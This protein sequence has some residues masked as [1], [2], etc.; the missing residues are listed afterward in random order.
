MYL[1]ARHLF[2]DLGYRRL[3][4]KLDSC[5]E[6]SAAAA[7]RLGFTYEGRYRQAIVYKGRNR[8]TDWFSMID[9]EWPRIRGADR[10]LARPGQLRR[11]RPA[12]D[13]PLRRPGG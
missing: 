3:E 1:L 2:D 10:G 13:H 6:P 4:W 5:N 9:A 12:A 7:R 11:R 8:D